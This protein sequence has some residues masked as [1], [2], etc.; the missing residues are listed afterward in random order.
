MTNLNSAA[1]QYH[2]THSNFV[3]AYKMVNEYVTEL[4]R[5]PKR[6][7]EETEGTMNALTNKHFAPK[8]PSAND[9]N[10]RVVVEF[11]DQLDEFT[12]NTIDLFNDHMKHI[13]ATEAYMKKA[14]ALESPTVGIIENPDAQVYSQLIPE[15][16]Q[17]LG[18]LK[19][20]KQR[21][22]DTLGW[23]EELEVN[24]ETIQG[25]IKNAA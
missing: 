6:F 13:D 12:M 21:A 24:W 1:E 20:I 19:E 22:D 25:E 17:L 18:G 9:T 23:L 10:M 16:E 14:V 8:A 15:V 3:E 7:L 2:F 5:L 11:M 4:Y